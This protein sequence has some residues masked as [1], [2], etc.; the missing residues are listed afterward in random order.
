MKIGAIRVDKDLMEQ[1]PSYADP[2]I[3]FIKE[4]L[5]DLECHETTRQFVY[6][7]SHDEFVSFDHHY[8]SDTLTRVYPVYTIVHDKES[9]KYW[10]QL[11]ANQYF[12]T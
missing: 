12:C 11:Q 3:V 6:T 5:V 4:S 8:H 7:G 2:F 1:N 9:G 10:F